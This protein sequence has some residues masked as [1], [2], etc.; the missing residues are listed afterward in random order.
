M[1]HD[2]KNNIILFL[3][4][5][6]DV[7]V[8]FSA[9]FCATKLYSLIFAP[10]SVNYINFAVFLVSMIFFFFMLDLYASKEGS[11]EST[12]ISVMIS[13]LAS[14]VILAIVSALFLKD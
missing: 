1:K 3:S 8:A 2:V 6:A 12:I 10:A 13:S 14:V 4:F 5:I 7:L 9:Y 11:R